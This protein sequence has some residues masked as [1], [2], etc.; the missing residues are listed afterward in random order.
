MTKAQKLKEKDQKTKF[1]STAAALCF[2]MW[3]TRFPTRGSIS[4]DSVGRLLRAF[5]SPGLATKG[6][7]CLAPP[8][9]AITLPS[10]AV[11]F[12]ITLP[13]A[14]VAFDIWVPTSWCAISKVETDHDAT[15]KP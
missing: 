11:A 12:A 1:L 14:A 5:H 6:V 2:F 4:G 9:Y 13:D 8:Q 7:T 15:H 3:T 10:A